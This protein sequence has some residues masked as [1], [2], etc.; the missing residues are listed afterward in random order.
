MPEI[1]RVIQLVPMLC[2][3]AFAFFAVYRFTM[4]NTNTDK[5]NIYA[6]KMDRLINKIDNI[7]SKLK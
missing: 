6:I 7:D 2:W 5:E 1:V 4:P 3:N